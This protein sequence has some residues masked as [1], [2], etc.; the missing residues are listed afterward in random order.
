[1]TAATVKTLHACSLQGFEHSGV[2]ER[3]ATETHAG[4]IVNGICHRS[5][6]RFQGRLTGSV[7]RQ[8]GTVRI[9][10]AIDEQQVDF[11]RRIE[12]R[13]RRMSNP[14]LAGDLLAIE[15]HLFIKRPAQGMEHAAL[16]NAAKRFG[17]GHTAAVMRAHEPRYLK[18]ASVA[19]Y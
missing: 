16:D 1:M 17:I 10:I 5:D 18:E 15:L 11:C 13:Q 12:M 2:S 19:T 6:R 4:C 7:V 3:N 14:V 8:I 9:G